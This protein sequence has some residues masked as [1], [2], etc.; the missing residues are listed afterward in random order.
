M[1]EPFLLERRGYLKTEFSD[2]SKAVTALCGTETWGRLGE[3]NKT[4]RSS[5]TAMNGF[6]AG[7]L[8]L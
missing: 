6:N 2:A 5:A 3:A 4:G 1:F 7:Y 8:T